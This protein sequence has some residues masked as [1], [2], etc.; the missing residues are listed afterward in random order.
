M[1]VYHL[2]NLNFQFWAFWW[3]LAEWIFVAFFDWIEIV[4]GSVSEVMRWFGK[5]FCLERDKTWKWKALLR[6]D[7]QQF[8][9]EQEISLNGPQKKRKLFGIPKSSL[10]INQ[11]Q[12]LS[13]RSETPLLRTHVKTKT[14]GSWRSEAKIT[15]VL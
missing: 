9:P 6:I 14:L 11:M 3:E 15:F 8:R 12:K 1:I 2:L 13:C 4:L 10:H 5:L 7:S